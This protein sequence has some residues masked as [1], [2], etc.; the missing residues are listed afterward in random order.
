MT[1]KRE[2]AL[3]GLR[4]IAALM[5]VVFHTEAPF[6]QG[7]Y[8]GVDVFFVLSGFLITSLL[9]RE[10]AERGRIDVLAF[11]LR[12]AR[13]LYPA[14]LFMLAG[15]LAFAALWPGRGWEAI[16]AVLYL[17]NFARAATGEPLV[18]GHTWSLAVEEQFYL[19]WPL[20][21][22]LLRWPLFV[23]PVLYVALTAFRWALGWDVGYPLHASGR[24]L[25]AL[26]TYL[27]P[28]PA[29]WAWP[30]LVTIAACAVALPFPSIAGL[31]VGITLAEL[32]S[33]VLISAAL[34]PGGAVRVLLSCPPL[35][36]L[37]LIS[38][39]IYLWHY[40]IIYVL[41]RLYSWET[42]LLFA[43]PCTIFMAWVSFVAVERWLMPST[44]QGPATSRA[45]LGARS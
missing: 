2:P 28:V 12:R 7:G 43:M 1:L 16:V 8:L 19:L 18:L 24:V 42:T 14:L 5:V 36:G 29:R 38:Y 22:P 23:L 32:A 34:Q 25:G 3:D 35:V 4:A 20:L 26:L 11:Y 39:A 27:P 10:L 17:S 40:P 41:K 9:R 44:R 31:T 15:F 21:L 45:R 33:A 6:L 37:G 30:A 13:R